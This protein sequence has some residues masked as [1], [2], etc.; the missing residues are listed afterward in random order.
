MARIPDVDPLDVPARVKATLDT[1]AAQ[2]GEPLANHLLYA[3]RPSIFKGVRGMWSAIEES[4]L[5]DPALVSLVNRRV[6]A[7]VGCVF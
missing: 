3:H 4:S 1:Q 6:A 5:L 7:R 2:W